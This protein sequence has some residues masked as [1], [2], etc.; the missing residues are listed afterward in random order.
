M[1]G[2]GQAVAAES[3]AAYMRVRENK[4]AMVGRGRKLE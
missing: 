2:L 4:E 1:R 3:F